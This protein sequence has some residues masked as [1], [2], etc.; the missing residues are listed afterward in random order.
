VSRPD[1]RAEVGATPLFR[2]LTPASLDVLATAFEPVQVEPGVFDPEQHDPGD[3]WLLGRTA[4]IVAVSVLHHGDAAWQSSAFLRRGDAIGAANLG[5]TTFATPTEPLPTRYEVVHAGT[6]WRLPADRIQAVLRQQLVGRSSRI[7]GGFAPGSTTELVDALQRWEWIGRAADTDM[8]VPRERLEL[9][10]QAEVRP[11]RAGDVLQREGEVDEALFMVGPGAAVDAL[12]SAT[13]HPSEPDARWVLG[14]GGMLGYGALRKERAPVQVQVVRD[15]FVFAWSRRTLRRMVGPFGTLSGSWVEAFLEA[16]IAVY[17][18]V[19]PVVRALA[20]SELLSSV[21]PGK[22]LALLQGSTVVDWRVGGAPPVPIGLQAGLG[23]VMN[24][25]VVGFRM[26]PALDHNAVQMLRFDATCV[27]RGHGDTEHAAAHMTCFGEAEC[28]RHLLGHGRLDHERGDAAELA[29]NRWRARVP[30]KAVFIP[31]RRLSAVLGVKYGEVVEPMP[32]SARE[33]ARRLLNN[34]RQISQRR[35]L[36]T[37]DRSV[38]EALEHASDRTRDDLNLVWVEQVDGRSPS[39]DDLGLIQDLA[40]HLARPPG[41]GGS[42]ERSLL[43]ELVPGDDDQALPDTSGDQPWTRVRLSAGEHPVGRL[44]DLLRRSPGYANVF[45]WQTAVPQARTRVHHAVDTCMLLSRD[46]AAPL[47]PAWPPETPYL[48][49]QL[50]R[51]TPGR[52][53]PATAL[54]LHALTEVGAP[55]TGWASRAAALQRWGRAATRRQVGIALGGGGAWGWA[56]VAL[57][58]TALHRGIPIDMVSGASFGSVAGGFFALGGPAALRYAIAHDRD[59]QSAV[60]KAM[61]TGAPIERYFDRLPTRMAAWADEHRHPNV[62]RN[63]R[64]LVPPDQRTAAE[65]PPVPLTH[66]PIPFFPVATE[67]IMGSEHALLT[68]SVGFGVRASGSLPPMFPIAREPGRNFADGGLS[69]N[70]PANVVE[71]EGVGIIVAS[72]IVPPPFVQDPRPVRSGLRGVV[73]SLNPLSRTVATVVGLQTLFNRSGAVD[74]GLAPVVF[75]SAWNGSMFFQIDKAQTIVSDT[76]ADQRLWQALDGLTSRWTEIR[77]PR[78][79]LRRD[80]SLGQGPQVPEG[81]A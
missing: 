47:P 10:L 42:G 53:L 20:S 61:V 62:A 71:T 40:T 38:L 49:A 34:A 68:G 50:V 69:Q 7:T 2:N 24:G 58:Q 19:V 59:I 60:N 52:P 13:T 5:G 56:H 21:D 81:V 4:E 51:T 8:L 73:S 48:Y 37:A 3:V 63:L 64:A 74:T 57:L 29:V 80:V 78:P 12:H 46:P 45:V 11:V 66:T 54:R 26:I 79:G 75:E 27:R 23:V 30:T 14:P 35:T 17:D 15:G 33:Q 76:T 72:N 32:E 44:V 39:A 70:V 6:V 22:L 41:E 77:R 31:A 9:V 18:H 43:V 25:E 67:L 16:R 36:A 1:F 55:E 65:L 28:A